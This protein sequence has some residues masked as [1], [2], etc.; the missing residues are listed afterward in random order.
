MADGGGFTGRRKQR[1]MKPLHLG[2]RA[3]LAAFIVWLALTVGGSL[4][5]TS[6]AHEALWES[7]SRGVGWPWLLA[8]MFATGLV[9]F[10]DRRAL[11]MRLPVT[12][13]TLRLAWLP[14]L[15]AVAACLLAAAQ[16]PPAALAGMVLLNTSLVA[17]SEEV[18][19]RGILLYGL[20][21]RLPV[22]PAVLVSSALFG[23]VHALNV[24]TT[25]DLAASLLQALAAALQ[26]VGLAAVRVRTHS[27]WPM[28]V[29]HAFYDC[30]LLLAAGAHPATAMPGA[31]SVLPVLFVLPIF[32]YGLFLLRKNALRPDPLPALERSF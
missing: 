13:A 22:L 18:M 3:S 5:K 27:L 12:I 2:L 14:F 31:M 17:L 19:F 1:R 7:A 28:I 23:A 21:T 4:G 30:G 26:G 25:G 32:V 16:P 15:Y 29:V 9:L 8:A 10:S 20:M 24:F 6:G 11:G